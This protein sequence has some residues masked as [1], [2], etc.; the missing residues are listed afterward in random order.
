V[1]VAASGS[2]AITIADTVKLDA[3]V[4][5]LS[6]PG[7]DG[8]GVIRGVQAAQPNTP[9][10]LLT[11][12]AGDETALALKGAMSGTFSLLLKPVTEGQLQDRL[13]TLLSSRT[14]A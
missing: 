7:I 3:L 4:T 11:G 12:Y 14:A 13:S 10:V 2:E 1:V 6:M 9:A 5:D 8:L